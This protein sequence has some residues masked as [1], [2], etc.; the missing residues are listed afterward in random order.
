MS[1]EDRAV[2]VRALCA[3]F[4]KDPTNVCRALFGDDASAG[5]A[6]RGS[7]YSRSQYHY[8]LLHCAPPQEEDRRAEPDDDDAARLPQRPLP[9]VP[10]TAPLGVQPPRHR[11]GAAWLRT[12]RDSRRLFKKPAYIDALSLIE[13]FVSPLG[14]TAAVERCFGEVKLVELKSRA[15]K[16]SP[17]ALAS[18]LRLTVQDLAGH[19]TT[20]S[21]ACAFWSRTPLAAHPAV[22]VPSGGQ[23][24][25]AS[26]ASQ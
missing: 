25:L 2:F 19:R 10:G 1:M 18:A 20:P 7:L 3:R 23:P 6:F 16:L 15:H 5:T 9:S 13:I 8:R 22:A 4:K 24:F 14:G 17:H 12:L 21:T 11:N 26:G